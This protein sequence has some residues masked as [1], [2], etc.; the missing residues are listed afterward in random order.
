[1]SDNS[2]KS[3]SLALV[4]PPM[5][6][7]AYRR[8]KKLNKM[9]AD[10][11]KRIALKPSK[12]AFTHQFYWSQSFRQRCAEWHFVFFISKKSHTTHAKNK[13]EAAKSTK[14]I[15]P[16]TFQAILTQCAHGQEYTQTSWRRLR[17]EIRLRQLDGPS[18]LSFT[19]PRCVT[20]KYQPR[21]LSKCHRATGW[22]PDLIAWISIILYFSK[23]AY[24]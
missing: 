3:S 23:H 16:S 8:Q 19:T 18:A 22:C 21:L 20:S 1:M 14:R 24:G 15:Q 10:Q 5:V 2:R 6:L 11:L 9:K 4:K 13:K 17:G 7:G 12:G